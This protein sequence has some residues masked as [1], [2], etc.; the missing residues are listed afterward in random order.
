MAHNADDIKKYEG[1]TVKFRC[2][3]L[4]RKKLPKGSFIVGRHIMTCCADDMAFLGY[5]CK[6]A[7]AGSL[8]QKEWVKVTATVTREF[9]EGYQGQGPV[10]HAVSVVKTKAPKEEVISFV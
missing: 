9:W 5:V 10:L 2:K 4:V 8:K 1:K 7:A 6:Y 3:A